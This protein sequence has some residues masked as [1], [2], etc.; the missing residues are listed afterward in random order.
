MVLTFNIDNLRK[1][2]FFYFT[3]CA[4]TPIKLFMHYACDRL[5]KFSSCMSLN[6]PLIYISILSNHKIF[7]STSLNTGTVMTVNYLVCI[8][9]ATAP[10]LLMSVTIFLM[11]CP[12]SL[13]TQM[14]PAVAS[15]Q[16]MF[17]VIQ[18]TTSPVGTEKVKVKAS[19][20]VR[21]RRQSIV[22]VPT[23]LTLMPTCNT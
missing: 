2:I 22:K 9:S 15:V 10:G 6:T 8:S 5:A 16:Y 14:A 1:I 7:V 12:P 23:K 3:K 20:T 19:T 13:D 4:G 18:S 11:Y 21:G 17:D